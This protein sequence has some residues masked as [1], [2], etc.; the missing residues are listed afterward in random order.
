[1]S[2][3][4]I[5]VVQRKT[6]GTGVRVKAP[7]AVLAVVALEALAVAPWLYARFGSVTLRF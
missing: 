4:C 6:S 2:R 3:L 5:G 1:M 7:N